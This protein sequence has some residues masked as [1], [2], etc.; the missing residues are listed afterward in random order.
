MQPDS[1]FFCEGNSSDDD[2]VLKEEF[3]GIVVKQGCL[4]KQVSIACVPSCHW[5]DVAWIQD[6]SFTLKSFREER[7]LPMLSPHLTGFISVL[8][9]F[10]QRTLA[11][12][13]QQGFCPV[14]QGLLV[15]P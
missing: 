12:A 2:V 8:F 1:G 13:W 10:A 15:L 3:R 4:L 14:W 7:N 11:V 9:A 6:Y 5:D